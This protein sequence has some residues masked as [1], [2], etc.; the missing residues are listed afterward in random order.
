MPRP[1][2]KQLYLQLQETYNKTTK[3]G[4]ACPLCEEEDKVSELI[5]YAYGELV[6]ADEQC[7]F[8]KTLGDILQ[9]YYQARNI[10]SLED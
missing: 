3:T 1:K 8:D 6:C 4:M 10:G 7:S 9:G 5:L 2:Y